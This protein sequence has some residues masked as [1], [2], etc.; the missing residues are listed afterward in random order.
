MQLNQNQHIDT[1]T[2][3]GTASSIKWQH[4]LSR[5]VQTKHCDSQH[6]PSGNLHSRTIF[7][8]APFSCGKKGESYSTLTGSTNDLAS[9]GSGCH[10][11]LQVVPGRYH[12]SL[13]SHLVPAKCR[14]RRATTVSNSARPKNERA[15]CRGKNGFG[16]QATGSN[17]ARKRGDTLLTWL[18]GFSKRKHLGK[19]APAT[20]KCNIWRRNASLACS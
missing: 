14:E 17:R 8:A 12:P 16:I 13:A 18:H 2:T 10:L 11:H 6:M 9:K 1:P 7:R 20:V 4:A 3:P 19:T 15:T 5:S